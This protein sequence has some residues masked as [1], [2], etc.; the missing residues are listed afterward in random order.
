VSVPLAGLELDV[1]PFASDQEITVSYAYWE[2]AVQVTGSSATG[3]VAGV[4][5]IELTG[6]AGSMQG[7][8]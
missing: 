4:G 1:Q 6:Y 7:R 3:P 8:F 2:D 5:C